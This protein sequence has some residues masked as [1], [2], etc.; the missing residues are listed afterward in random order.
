MNSSNAVSAAQ[1]GKRIPT[2]CYQ[3]VNGPDLLTVKLVDGVA[4]GSSP[5]SPC[6]ACIRPTA[7]SASSP[8]ASSR[9]STIRTASSSR[10]GGPIRAR[11]ATR[12]PAGSKSAGTR[13]SISSPRSS[14]RC[15]AISSTSMGI[16][17]LLSPSAAPARRCATWA[18]FPALLRAWGGP[19]D[20]RLGA[21]GTGPSQCTP[22]LDRFSYSSGYCQ[23]RA[24][25]VGTQEGLRLRYTRSST[26]RALQRHGG[27][28][29]L[30]IICPP[31][32]QFFKDFK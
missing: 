12:T 9:S 5:T 2:Y 1:A 4:T 18:R 10:C 22:D 14:A 23:A 15:A 28:S 7:R 29:R 27:S 24:C 26:R 30:I 3:C 32:R 31:P 20:Q 17:A 19:V 8:T 25:R 11:A 13:P 21:G 16:R 6:A